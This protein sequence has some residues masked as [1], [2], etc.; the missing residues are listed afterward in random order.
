MSPYLS[1]PLIYPHGGNNKLLGCL[2][3]FQ[4]GTH[5]DFVLPLWTSGCSCPVKCYVHCCTS[6][7]SPP[8]TAAAAAANFMNALPS[9][10]ILQ[11]VGG[12][13]GRYSMKNGDVE[14]AAAGTHW[15]G[16]YL[17]YHLPAS[18][19]VCKSNVLKSQRNKKPISSSDRQFCYTNSVQWCRWLSWN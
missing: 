8:R 1:W 18:L 3:L 15:C 10:R 2:W 16:N 11:Y 14:A 19:S 13:Q 17:R 5:T 9:G 6:R 12:I 7:S 4:F